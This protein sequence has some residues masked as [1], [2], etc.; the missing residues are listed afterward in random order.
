MVASAEGEQSHVF[1]VLRQLSAGLPY[2]VTGTT[3]IALVGVLAI[4]LSVFVVNFV[5]WQVKIRRVMKQ[6]HGVSHGSPDRLLSLDHNNRYRVWWVTPFNAFTVCSHPETVKPITSNKRDGL[7]L[8]EGS[9]WQ[10]NRR[11]LTPAF[12]FDILKNYVKL[13]SESADVLLEK[14]MS[15]DPGASVELFDDVGLMTLDNILKCSLGYKS[16]CQTDGKSAPYI[17]AVHDLTRL[18]DERTN[19]L[20]HYIDF[21]Y[22]LSASG[23]RF[24][25]ACKVVHCFSEQVITER[26]EELKKENLTFLSSKRGKCLALLDILLQAKDEDGTGLSVSEIQDEV[27]TFLFGGHHTTASGISWTLFHLAQNKDYQDKCRREVKG[28]L[29]GRTDMTWND[30]GKLPFTTM[31]IKESMRCVPPVARMVRS[32]KQDLTFADGKWLPKGSSAF[33]DIAG[34]HRNREIWP[35]PTVYDPY[36][37][38]P[39]NSN[40]RRPHAFLPFSAGPRNCIGQNFAMAEMKV[41]LALILQRFHLELDD[42]KPPAVPCYRITLQAKDG[43]WVKLHPLKTNM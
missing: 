19:N 15:R 34:L 6:F 16:S 31:C 30:V 41:A 39:E 7:L 37:F 3:L 10:R 18:I 4:R 21:I 27:N 14:W 22:Y 38:S 29:Q 42:T 35:N 40:S 5:V 11:L 8:S 23:R 24:R 26:K 33:A 25:Q 36:R 2:G 28:V 9:K 17:L 43:I 1:D 13:F 20:P 12:H 32:L